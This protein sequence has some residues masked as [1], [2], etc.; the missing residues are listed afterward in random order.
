MSANTNRDFYVTV[1]VKTSKVG[2]GNFSFFVTDKN[3]SNFFVKLGINMNDN[4]LIS[5]FVALENAINYRLRLIVVKPNNEVKS[6]FG[7][8]MNEEEGIFQFNL[9]EEYKDLLGQYKC[10]FW[11][12]STVDIVEEIVTTDPFIYTIKPSVVNDVD[13][14]I[15]KD[16]QYP[17]LFQLITELEQLQNETHLINENTRE[18]QQQTEMLQENTKELKENFD[19]LIDTGI[20]KFI[21]EFV[22]GYVETEIEEELESINNN[23]S[24]IIN[25]NITDINHSIDN[26]NDRVSNTES[27]IRD[28]NVKNYEQDMN[29]KCLFS[30]TSYSVDAEFQGNSTKL[31]NSKSGTGYINIVEGNTKVNVS[32]Q[33]NNITLTKSYV[34]EGVNHIQLQYNGKAKPYIYGNTLWID[35]DTQEL[36]HNFDNTKSLS[37]QSSFESEYDEELKKYKVEY[38]ISTT[39]KEFGKGGRLNNVN[40]FI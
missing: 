15:K 40:M 9:N 16:S 18:L 6:I 19:E 11:V 24:N 28:I 27:D 37:L 13:D 25:E 23:I 34:P 33:K 5:N 29:L 17:L 31:I 20:K 38:I 35:N 1:D 12:Y 26:I 22:P 32:S 2:N 39:D 21:E 3:T 36:L 8:L 10:E 7:Q 14:V 4:S 30:H